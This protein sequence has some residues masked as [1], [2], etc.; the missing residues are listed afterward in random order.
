MVYRRHPRPLQVLSFP[1]EPYPADTVTDSTSPASICGDGVTDGPED[2][3][4]ESWCSSTCEGDP[5]PC[6]STQDGCPDLDWVQIEGGPF[7]MGSTSGDSDELPIHTVTVPSFEMMRSEVT[8][9][10]YHACVVAGACSALDMEDFCNWSSSAGLKE[11]HPANCMS[12]Y[13]LNEFAEWVGARLPTEAEWEFAARGGDRDV[14]YPWGDDSPSCTLVSYDQCESGTSAVCTHRRGDSLDGLC[15]M[16][17]GVWEWVQDEWH[18]SYNGAPVDGSGW[19]EA[20][21]CPSDRSN[22]T[23]RVLRGGASD[24]FAN[25]LRVANRGSNGPSAQ[26]ANHGGRLS[27]DLH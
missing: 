4:G 18:D 11:G 14:T 9:G 22:S 5:P 16:A 26:Y 15:D 1:I 13:Q 25:D 17:G 3:D 21:G 19:C 20:S 2:C 23:S 7:S 12:W 24:N 27:R 6:A 10:M 8:I